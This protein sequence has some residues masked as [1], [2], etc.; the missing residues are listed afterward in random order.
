MASAEFDDEPAP[1]ALLLDRRRERGVGGRSRRTCDTVVRCPPARGLARTPA[2]GLARTPAQ[3]S[4]C[5]PAQG[6]A[7]TPA[8]G[9]ARTPAQGLAR[10]PAQG[11]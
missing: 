7:C 2:Q 11:S 4:A 8:Q 1:Q 3:G 5:T 6:S 9:L 10:T